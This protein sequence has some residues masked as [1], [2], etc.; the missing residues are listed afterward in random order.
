LPLVHHRSVSPYHENCVSRSPWDDGYGGHLSG[1][2]VAISAYSC[3]LV[4]VANHNPTSETVTS[5]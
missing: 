1:I 4:L 2:K 3:S 5:P